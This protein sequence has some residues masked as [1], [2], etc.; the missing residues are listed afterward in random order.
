MDNINGHEK[1]HW[2]CKPY[3]SLVSN[4]EMF[5]LWLFLKEAEWRGPVVVY[6]TLQGQVPRP[7]IYKTI[8]QNHLT[9]MQIHM[10]PLQIHIN[11]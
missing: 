3:S 1:W 8:P 7:I 11:T 10:V 9:N 5:F 4:S 2:I 6:Q